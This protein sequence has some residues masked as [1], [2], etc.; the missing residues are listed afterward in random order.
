M[1]DIQHRK[2]IEFLIDK[3]Y[4]RVITDDLIG[5]FFTEVIKIDWDKHM[6]IMYDFWETT[7]LGKMKYKGNPMVKHI[8]LNQKEPMSPKHFERW[9]E[10]WE[11]T[12][13]ENFSGQKADEAVQRATQIGELMKYMITQHTQG[14]TSY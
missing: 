10:L 4:K 14:S 11:T 3:F 7:L 9:L 2:D 6:P 12:I 13:K 1:K 8:A 5:F